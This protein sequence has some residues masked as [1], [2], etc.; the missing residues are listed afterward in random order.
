M[1]GNAKIDLTKLRKITTIAANKAKGKVY[2]T[3]TIQSWG[4][5]VNRADAEKEALE[6]LAKKIEG[7]L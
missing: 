6:S 4:N 7:T 1:A 2:V 5:Q 3:A